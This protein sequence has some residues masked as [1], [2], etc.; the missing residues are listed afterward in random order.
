[1][2]NGL[3][4][5]LPFV[6]TTRARRARR[7][8]HCDHSVDRDQ[9][10]GRVITVRRDRQPIANRFSRNGATQPCRRRRH[11]R[12][13]NPL[14]LVAWMSALSRNRPDPAP[15]RPCGDRR[16]PTRSYG[17]LVGPA[18]REVGRREAQKRTLVTDLGWLRPPG[19]GRWCHLDARRDTNRRP[20]TFPSRRRDGRPALCADPP[21]G[22]TRRRAGAMGRRRRRHPRVCN[23]H[24]S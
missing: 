12:V 22:A 1:M 8:E 9:S 4:S 7:L 20:P 24:P 5:P 23:P 2:A 16:R 14:P 3:P 18:E 11:P 15:L 21:S 6:V 17:C 13:R 10:P 19:A